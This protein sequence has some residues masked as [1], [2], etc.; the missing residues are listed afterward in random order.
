MAGSPFAS[1]RL[2]GTR[3]PRSLRRGK[4]AKG[5]RAS[6]FPCGAAGSRGSATPLPFPSPSLCCPC[7]FCER[8][9]GVRGRRPQGAA[10]RKC[11]SGNGCRRPRPLIRSMASFLELL[12]GSGLR[13]LSEAR[14][15]WIWIDG[16]QGSQRRN[17]SR[18]SAGRNGLAGAI[19]LRSRPDFVCFDRPG[20]R[21]HHSTASL[22]ANSRRRQLRAT[23]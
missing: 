7:L 4:G 15:P 14:M 8:R 23:R 18:I 19:G 10:G 5:G 11:L 22:Q 9:G 17:S 3:R 6:G 13:R 21:G 16:S 2:P 20:R 1:L 12:A